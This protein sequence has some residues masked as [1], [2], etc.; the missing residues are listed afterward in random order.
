MKI[1]LKFNTKKLFATNQI[2][3]GKFLRYKRKRIGQIEDISAW[4][5]EEVVV[6]LKTPK[7]K[8]FFRQME[9]EIG[10]KFIHDPIRGLK[11]QNSPSQPQ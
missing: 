5:K 7:K 6:T 4:G 8:S 9:S 1:N 10:K 11:H 2:V 3:T